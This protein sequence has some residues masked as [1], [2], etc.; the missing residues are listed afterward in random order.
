MELL[1]FIHYSM[2][3]KNGSLMDAN[4]ARRFCSQSTFAIRCSEVHP[5]VQ[6]RHSPMSRRDQV[7]TGLRANVH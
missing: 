5:F 7:N 4:T 1:R 2:V 6:S 3:K